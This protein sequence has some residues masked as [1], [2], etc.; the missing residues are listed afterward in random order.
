MIIKKIKYLVFIYNKMAKI[1][2]SR[3]FQYKI[4]KSIVL[5]ILIPAAIILFSAWFFFG[6]SWEKLNAKPSMHTTTTTT[7]TTT[8]AKDAIDGTATD[9]CKG[10]TQDKCNMDTC[11]WDSDQNA[12][13]LNK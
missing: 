6:D 7:T 10:M 2:S 1:S 11:I 9:S 5:S 8:T 4:V 12:C 3:S 13:L